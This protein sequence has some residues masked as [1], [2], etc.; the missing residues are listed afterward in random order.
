MF[1]TDG[2]LRL[3]SLPPMPTLKAT[4]SAKANFGIWQLAQLMDESFESIFSENNFLPRAAL[5][6]ISV[7]SS[8]KKELIT[9]MVNM[10]A[11]KERIVFFINTNL[12]CLP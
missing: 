6:C 2:V 7:F 12:H 4:V 11:T 5:D 10:E 9:T 8:P 3:V 1:K